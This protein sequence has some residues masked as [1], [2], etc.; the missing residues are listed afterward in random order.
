MMKEGVKKM[1]TIKDFYKI[2]SEAETPFPL[3]TDFDTS[4]QDIDWWSEYV[5]NFQMFDYQFMKQFKSFVY[6]DQDEDNTDEENLQDFQM[7]F[8]QIF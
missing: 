5:E 8:L 7:L 2:S 1:L 3:L 6:F 4:E